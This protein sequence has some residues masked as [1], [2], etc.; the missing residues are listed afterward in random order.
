MVLYST[1]GNWA[2]ERSGRTTGGAVCSTKDGVERLGGE[3]TTT[4]L[5]AVGRSG[6]VVGG[7]VEAGI[8]SIRNSIRGGNV[9]AGSFSCRCRNNC[10]RARDF[11]K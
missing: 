7:H 5:S 8:A 6:I 1:S 10:R 3:G 11:S 4:V 9:A 2:G